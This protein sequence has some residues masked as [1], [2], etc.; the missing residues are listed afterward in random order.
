M[1]LSWF[2]FKVNLIFL[3][4]LFVPSGADRCECSSLELLEALDLCIDWDGLVWFDL[5]CCEALDSIGA[6][7]LLITASIVIP[8]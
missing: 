2:S 5:S 1:M 3:T 6:S 4:F 8:I 7:F